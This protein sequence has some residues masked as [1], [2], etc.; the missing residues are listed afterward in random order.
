[1]KRKTKIVCTLGPAVSDR[2]TLRDLMLTGMNCARLN[3]SHGSHEEHLVR[4]NMVKELSRELGIHVAL[5]LDTKG[6]EIRTKTSPDGKLELEKGETFTLYCTEKEG[7]L[8]GVS[9]TYPNLCKEVSVGTKILLDDGLI[10]LQVYEVAGTDI[11]CTILN[12]GALGNNKSMNLPDVSIQLP[13]ITERD[14]K[15]L[16]FACQHDFDFIAA[17]F[18]RKAE[19]VEII[20]RVLDENGG[21]DIRIISK[22]ENQE[23]VNNAAEIIEASNGIMVA[24]GDLGVEIPAE[25]VPLV[26]KMLITECV[27]RGKPVITATQMLDSMIR[28]PRPTRAEVSDV[29]N[30]VFDGTSCVM[31]SGETAN[32]KYPVEAL[33]TMVRIVERAD[34]AQAYTPTYKSAKDGEMTITDAISHS[35]CSTAANLNAKAILSVTKSG[36]TARMISRFRPTCPIIA[37]TPVEKVKRQLAISWG[38]TPCYGPDVETTDALFDLAIEKAQEIGMV[39]KGDTVVITAGVPI[40]VSGTTNLIKAQ[41]I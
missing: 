33:S 41:K 10:E 40:G 21:T 6:P 12:G 5:M 34:R 3:F 30:A 14:E 11:H 4:A 37:V 28:N 15:D 7:S 13:A 36:Y 22:I 29:A 39:E 16:I 24:R 31:L 20:R 23:G 8:R 18:V 1:M 19:D 2:D 25:E 35:T 27:R 9:I 38:I 26:Q 17:S 32:G